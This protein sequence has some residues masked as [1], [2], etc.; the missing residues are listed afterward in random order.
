MVT[1]DYSDWATN[2]PEYKVTAV[3][4]TP[5]NG[6]PSQECHHWM[7]HLLAY[8]AGIIPPQPRCA[9][10]GV[11]S[12]HV[13]PRA[14]GR[15]GEGCCRHP[16]PPPASPTAAT[17]TRGMRMIP[18]ETPIA[19]TSQPQRLRC[20]VWR[21]LA[22]LEDFALGFRLDREGIA[23]YRRRNRGTRRSLA[24]GGIELRMRLAPERADTITLRQ[25]ASLA[26]SS[27]RGLRGLEV[28]PTPTTASHRASQH[29]AAHIDDA[30]IHAARAHAPRRAEALNPVD[31]SAV[32][33]QRL[34]HPQRGLAASWEDVGRHNALDKL[35]GALA[36]RRRRRDGRDRLS[37]FSRISVNC[38]E[39]S[40]AFGH[41]PIVIAASALTALSPRLA[42]EAGHASSV[43]RG[44]DGLRGLHPPRTYR[45][46]TGAA[47][48]LD[49]LGLRWPIRSANSS[50]TSRTTRRCF[51]RSPNIWRSSGTCRMRGNLILD[52][53]RR[54]PAAS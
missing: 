3:Q 53:L 25:S 8:D 40:D 31:P 49:E 50:L 1:S 33:V 2:C 46:T 15:V 23:Q 30:V 4:V 24:E 11:L 13:L 48:C 34:S 52:A 41:T 10:E 22:D 16:N 51:R 35:A 29:L 32:H 6:P 5:T 47:C 28:W 43:S 42:D 14:A 12:G 38:A 7:T 21:R 36:R 19:L 45:S 27:G 39:G 26:G 18:E 37:V 44:S 20:D 54:G 9:G 17:A